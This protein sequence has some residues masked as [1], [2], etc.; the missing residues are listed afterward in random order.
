MYIDKKNGVEM[1]RLPRWLSG[2]LFLPYLFMC[3][4][5]SF[6]YLSCDHDVLALWLEERS[7]NTVERIKAG[8]T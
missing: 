2:A 4:L 8:K 3:L 5:N 6:V 7:A 1:R